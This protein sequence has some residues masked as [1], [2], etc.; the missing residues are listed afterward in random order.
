[1]LHISWLQHNTPQAPGSLKHPHQQ[2]SRSSRPEALLFY[3]RG[4]PRDPAAWPHP[5]TV[6]AIGASPA[7]AASHSP[8]S[9]FQSLTASSEPVMTVLPSSQ[10]ATKR[11]S[12]S[13]QRSVCRQRPLLTSQTFA[14][15]SLDP[16]T[17]SPPSGEKPTPQTWSWW[18]RSR[19]SSRQ[20]SGDQTSATP[21]SDAEATVAPSGEKQMQCTASPCCNVPLHSKLSRFQTLA[22]RSLAPVARRPPAPKA[23][24]YSTSSWPR[25]SAR[26]LPAP[27]SQSV[28]PAGDLP[29]L[30]QAKVWPSGEKATQK[31]CAAAAAARSQTCSQRPVSTRQRLRAASPS[32]G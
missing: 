25:S 12:S 31:R 32:P 1:M 18:P 4:G 26:S 3:R 27:R 17:S 8:L 5:S 29:P 23:S 20:S 22:V 24:E 11:T 15:R 13:P 10:K 16:V 6:I 9:T 2:A 19:A 30:P 28:A 7:N 14:V 21:S